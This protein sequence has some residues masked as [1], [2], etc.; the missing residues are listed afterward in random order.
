M[1]LI[2]STKLLSL[3]KHQLLEREIQCVL[4]ALFSSFCLQLSPDSSFYGTSNLNQMLLTPPLRI[5]LHSP[6]HRRLHAL[7]SHHTRFMV[8]L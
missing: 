1:D 2:H 7:K 5:P 4:Y 3:S 8:L 6:N